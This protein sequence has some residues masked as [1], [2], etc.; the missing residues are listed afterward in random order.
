MVANQAGVP[1]SNRAASDNR[2]PKIGLSDL[3]KDGK[4]APKR[5][6]PGSN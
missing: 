4:A 1:R 5:L 2:Q 3:L 6:D